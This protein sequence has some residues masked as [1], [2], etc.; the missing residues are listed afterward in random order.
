MELLSYQFMDKMN[1]NIG[2]LHYDSYDDDSGDSRMHT[3]SSSTGDSRTG[4]PISP[5]KRKFDDVEVVSGQEYQTEQMAKMSCL[6][7]SQLGNPADGDTRPDPWSH[8]HNPFE[9]SSSAISGLHAGGLYSP[10]HFY[11]MEQPLALTKH[12]SDRTLSSFHPSLSSTER[13]QNRP[14]VI[15]CA[16]ANNRTCSLSNCHMSPN[17]FSSAVK[18][19]A[20]ANTV[21]DPV[22]EEHFRRSLGNIYKEPEV[23]S[24]SVSITGSVD[25]HFAQAL[26]DTWLQI[27][28]KGSGSRGHEST[29]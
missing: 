12:S 29:S 20:D 24:N 27:K 19:K 7:S 3:L 2:G 25:D 11:S 23:A 4:T 28:A 1:N 5:T 6:I 17:G 13:Q 26:G 21:C 22:I 9:H 18:S 16:P 10:F 8:C 14:S 15:T